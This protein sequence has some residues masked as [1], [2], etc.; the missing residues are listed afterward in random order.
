M[1]AVYKLEKFRQ[2][3]VTPVT[4]WQTSDG[5]LFSC[6]EDA[7]NHQALLDF[8]NWYQSHTIKGAQQGE[9]LLWLRN[10]A[11]YLRGMLDAMLMAKKI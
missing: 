5:K 11:E 1:S 9:V 6:K 2:S 7:G 4:S 10:N 8:E 3:K